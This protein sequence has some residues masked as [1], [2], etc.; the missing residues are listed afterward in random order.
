MNYRSHQR[1]N[2]QFPQD[3]V[4]DKFLNRLTQLGNNLSKLEDE[5]IFH[6]SEGYAKGIVEE[7]KLSNVQLRKF[8]M[9]IRNVYERYLDY[10][11]N[12]SGKSED[13]KK[14]KEE[15]LKYHLYRLYAITHY[16]VNRGV[17]KEKNGEKF[18]KLM[19]NI[20]DS[21]VNNF[22]K[23]NLRK[24]SDFFMAMVAYSKRES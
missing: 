23:E 3:S 24:A 5:V 15:E 16:Q 14:K 12:F 4:V 9:E 2:T 18:L 21:L 17:I 19:D 6:P 11:L 10:E 1:R 20:V 7:L 22:N 13:E 8:Y